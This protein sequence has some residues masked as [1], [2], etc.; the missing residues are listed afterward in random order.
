[1]TRDARRIA[2]DARRT[3]LDARRIALLSSAALLALAPSILPGQVP[4]SI[5]PAQVRE[6]TLSFDGH[7]TVGDFTGVTTEV[8]GRITGGRSLAEVRGWVEAPARSLRTGNAKRDRDMYKSLEVDKFE[9]IRFDLDRALPGVAYGDSVVTTFFGQFTIHGVTRPDSF[10]ASVVFRDGA[11]RVR[12]DLPLN[13]K[14]YKIG[15]LSKMLGI[16]KMHERIEV[17]VDVTFQ[18]E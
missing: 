8:S 10:P 18:P 16:L 4:D 1:M 9:T 2:L 6:G 14:D 5:P 12:A 13:L 17:H 3:A 15:G 11:I 7:A